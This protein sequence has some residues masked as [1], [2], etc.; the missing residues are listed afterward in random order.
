MHLLYILILQCMQFYIVAA[1]ETIINQSINQPI[2]RFTSGNM[3]HNTQ[4]HSTQ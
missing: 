1:A 4:T 2:K 3:V